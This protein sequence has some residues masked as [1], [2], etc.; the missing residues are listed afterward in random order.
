[1][2][3]LSLLLLALL[4]CLCVLASCDEPTTPPEG[5]TPGGEVTPGGNE[6]QKPDDGETP[7]G[8][9]NTPCVHNYG[10]WVTVTPAAC[11]TAGEEKRACDLC[12]EEEKRP[13]SSLSHDEEFHAAQAPTCT[14]KGWD[15]YVTCKREGCT[16]TTYA[17]KAALNHDEESHAAQAPTCTEKGWDAYVTCKREGCTYTTYA[18]KPALDHSHA[19]GWAYDANSHY[20][21]CAREGCEDKA[22]VAPHAYD[23]ELD[24]DCNIC[25]AVRATHC[26]H[27][28]A[29]TVKGYAATCTADGK[30]DGRKC[31]ACGETLTAQE[32]I[33]ALGHDEE[34]HAAQ[35]PTCTEKGWDAYVICKRE[36]CTYTTYLEKAALNHDEESHAA[37][38]PTCEEKGWDA[39]VTC[40]RKGCGYTT[41][42]EKPAEGHNVTPGW[43]MREDRHWHPCTNDGCDYR[44]NEGPHVYT[45]DFDKNCNTC[46]YIREVAPCAHPSTE[47]ILGYPAT[48]TEKGLTDGAKCLVCGETA[49]AQEDIPALGHDEKTHAAQ[50]Q[51]C[52]GIG[53]DEYVTCEREGCDYTTYEERGPIGH[54]VDRNR[55]LQYDEETHYYFCKNPPCEQKLEQAPHTPDDTGLCAVCGHQGEVVEFTFEKVEGGYAVTGYFGKDMTVEF[56]STHKGEPVI[57]IKARAFYD[58]KTTP[59]VFIIPDSVLRIEDYAFAGCSNLFEIQIGAG[60]TEIGAGAFDACARLRRVDF[61]EGSQL[62]TIGQQ[63][64][65]SCPD[66]ASIQL[67]DGLQK[68]GNA[69]F[70]KSSLTGIIIPAS[71]I[72]IG[73]CAFKDSQALNVVNFL[74]DSQLTK[75]GA[76]AF[77]GCWA[78]SFISIPDSVTEIGRRAFAD[79][80]GLGAVEFWHNSQ[81]KT[82]GLEAFAECGNLTSFEFPEGLAHI[83]THA[84]KG[85][86]SL[87]SITLPNSLLTIGLGAF[88]ECDLVES[89]SLPFIGDALHNP[90]DTHLDWIFNLENDPTRFGMA[91]ARIPNGLKTV[92]ITDGFT[93]PEEAF[94]GYSQIENVTIAASVQEIGKFAFSDCTGLKKVIFAEGGA[95]LHI[96]EAAFTRCVALAEISL[97][98]GLKEIGIGAFSDTGIT[99]VHIPASVTVIQES[100]F[101]ACN[102]LTSVTFGKNSCLTTIGR[103]AFAAQALRTVEIPA[104]VTEIGEGAFDVLWGSL[105]KVYIEDIGKFCMI[106]FADTGSTPVCRG[107]TLYI[108]GRAVDHLVI[109]AWVEYISAYAFCGL[110]V[111]EIS[112][113]ENSKLTTIGEGAFNSSS[114]RILRLPE[115]VMSIEIGAFALCENLSDFTLPAMHHVT[116][117]QYAFEGTRGI[118]TVSITTVAV[119]SLSAEI[120]RYGINKLTTVYIIGGDV[121]GEYLL[122][123]C[124]AI[125]CVVIDDSAGEIGDRAFAN[126]SNLQEVVFGEKS[127]LGFIGNYAFYGCGKLESI[128]LPVGLKTIGEG[129]FEYCT[130][131]KSI[132]VPIHVASIGYGAFR[133]CWNLTS[134]TLPF[135]GDGNTKTHFGYIFGATDYKQ[136]NDALL[137]TGLK[138]V[139]V[140]RADSI[141]SYAFYG[142]VNLTDVVMPYGV[143]S[144][145]ESAFRGCTGLTSISVPHSV[146]SIGD[147]AFRGC[148]GLLNIYLSVAATKIDNYA[149]A[150]CTKLTSITIPQSVTSIGHWVLTGCTGLTEIAVPSVEKGFRYLFGDVL[151]ESLKKVTVLG[152]ESI[153]E[154]VFEGCADLTTIILPDSVQSIGKY[155]FLECTSLAKIRIPEGVKNISYAAF[156]GCE[157]LMHITIPESVTSIDYSAFEECTSLQTVTMSASVTFID[158]YAFSC[159]TGLSAIYFDGTKAEWEAITKEYHWD[160]DTGNYTVSCSDGNITKS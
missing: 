143:G 27:P 44:K 57:A 151:P 1:M 149:F 33:P 20:H 112:F 74:L 47:P 150:Y 68:I 144:I 94:S 111:D 87:K 132:E 136:N 48:C 79:C 72:E 3:K 108:D 125:T 12:G 139:T 84:F 128:T 64:F 148:S 67:P 26:S 55:G 130:R 114:V 159:C 142:C 54:H 156:F 160:W 100:A 53:W 90:S 24:A 91:Y 99:T 81:L 122:A 29:E 93:I 50:A 107:A 56:P 6:T 17:E 25:G 101:R 19:T 9:E 106:K 14:E 83:E 4:L 152:G 35:A 16:Y 5:E 133:D 18:E 103:E 109:P 129:A 63:A 120:A 31:V 40:K 7:G 61:A 51:T 121:I 76:Q 147:S 60:V 52:E 13:T 80:R 117:A 49:T 36:G 153:G 96:G 82:I 134:I 138:N 97:P 59:T 92:V 2:K 58:N 37:Q 28:E 73:E 66:L 126:L 115:S 85:C 62:K 127:Q 39:Y 118:E 15:A 145:G 71:V 154:R 140:T 38:A 89:I 41:Y 113:E 75:I 43:I 104:S 137:S 70:E 105:E 77:E 157:S 11:E 131:L 124:S 158:S 23:G 88:Y 46:G 45:D 146:L 141:G 110:E 30:T 78:L 10:E 86:R 98:E 21:A 116:I 42:A 155:A 8:D 65:C 119:E 32:Q 22:D 95:L 135:V 123:D 102:Y 34:S 69:A